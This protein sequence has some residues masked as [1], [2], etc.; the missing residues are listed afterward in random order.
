MPYEGDYDFSYY[1]AAKIAY[2]SCDDL[3]KMEVD[4]LTESGMSLMDALAEVGVEV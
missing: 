4:S 3:T 1:S 2:E